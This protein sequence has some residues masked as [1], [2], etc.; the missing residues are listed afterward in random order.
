MGISAEGIRLAL[1]L[2]E[3]PKH[4][5]FRITRNILHYISEYKKAD[6]GK[7]ESTI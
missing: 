7:Q 2:E 6:D 5:W 3:L 1:E 4:R